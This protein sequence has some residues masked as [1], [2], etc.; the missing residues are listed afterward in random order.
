MAKVTKSAS[1]LGV[2]LVKAVAQGL[3]GIRWHSMKCCPLCLPA[4]RHGAAVARDAVHLPEQSPVRKLER[5]CVGHTGTP[6]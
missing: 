2:V 6:G 1:W 5:K 3:A 4:A